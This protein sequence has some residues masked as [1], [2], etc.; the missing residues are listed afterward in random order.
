MEACNNTIGSLA[1]MLPN[2]EQST[3]IDC[4]LFH[5]FSITP[6]SKAEKKI[7]RYI[8]QSIDKLEM[9]IQDTQDAL[10]I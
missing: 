7:N 9:D 8:N 3:I 2:R 5:N 1:D 6:N 4:L 10:I